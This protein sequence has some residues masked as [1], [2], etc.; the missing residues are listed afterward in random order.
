MINVIAGEMKNL[1]FAD[2]AINN[3]TKAGTGFGIVSTNQGKIEN[4]E[5]EKVK[6]TGYQASQVGMIGTNTGT[7]T[8]ASLKNIEISVSSTS[9]YVGGLA[10]YS[11]GAISNIM[12]EGDAVDY[13][14]LD[15]LPS[16]TLFTYRIVAPY[17][18][19]VGGIV[20][21]TK[22]DDYRCFGQRNLCQWL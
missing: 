21:G 20:G 19:G 9:S 17:S 12:A 14:S 15:G 13:T 3:G 1:R 11:T 4:C 8:N 2:I 10:G 18:E 6:L 16:D 7:I 5:F 22:S